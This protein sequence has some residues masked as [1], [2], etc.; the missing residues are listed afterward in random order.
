[1]EAMELG[2]ELASVRDSVRVTQT[3]E[4]DDV[5]RMLAELQ[6]NQLELQKSVQAIA[7]KLD[8]SNP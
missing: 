7:R 8:I 4:P 1:M 6:Q 2:E 5:R 3:P